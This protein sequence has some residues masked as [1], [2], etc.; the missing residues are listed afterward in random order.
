MQIVSLGNNLHEMSE[1]IFSENY[2]NVISLSSAESFQRVV[3]IIDK[4]GSKYVGTYSEND[5]FFFFQL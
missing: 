5:F 4:Y 2:E 3:A 1:P